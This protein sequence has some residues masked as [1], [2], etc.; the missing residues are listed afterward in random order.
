MGFPES[1]LL[2]ARRFLP[3]F[4]TQFFGA[5]NDNAFKLAMLTLISYHVSN[6]LEQSQYYQAIAGAL[7]IVPF[8]L[9]SATAGQL[10]DKFDKARLTIGIK[11]FEMG[12]MIVGGFALYNESIVLMLITLTGMG[13][14]STFFGPI[15]Y[16]ILPDHLLRGELLGAT[17]LI[18]ASTFLAILLGTTLGTLSIGSSHPHVG[19]AVALT[20]A[21]AVLGLVSS[22]FIPKALPKKSDFKIDWRLWQATNNM[23][24]GSLHNYRILPVIMTI[25]WFWLIGA[26]MLTKL[27]DYTHYILMAQASVF[28]FFLA[29]FSIG[30]ALG[31]IA[32]GHL[33]AGKITLRYVPICMLFLSFF[34]FDLYLASPQSHT[35]QTLS[36]LLTFL[37]NWNNVRITTDFFFF[38]FS[39]GLFIVPLYTYIQVASQE[40]MRARTIATNNIFNALFMLIGSG[41]VMLLLYL[42]MSIPMVFLILA[43]LNVFVALGL[44]MTLF[45]MKEL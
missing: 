32:I 38:S 43:I 24:R 29:L 25:S 17:S 23:L 10:A 6:N 40:N 31:S 30:I 1:Y 16:A 2:R 37:S 15:K 22:L 33:L 19:Y 11:I 39:A 12:L 44:W 36:P 3:L 18:E 8:F 9:F 45:R 34:A 27:P 41:L 26:V 28:A 35:I 42:N 14:H 13:V 4:L 21:I 7:F 20:N 5:F